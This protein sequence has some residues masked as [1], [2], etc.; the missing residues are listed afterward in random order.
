M[1]QSLLPSTTAWSDDEYGRVAVALLYPAYRRAV[2]TVGYAA[3][4][5]QLNY[6]LDAKLTVLSATQKAI[7]LSLA[8]QINADEQSYQDAAKDVP[9]VTKVGEI[10][11]DVEKGLQRRREALAVARAR[12]AR[13]VDHV[14][15]PYAED[16]LTG[17]A[18]N[19][20][21]AICVNG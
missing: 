17:G 11:R 16:I 12:L 10:G 15:N 21:N 3:A 14:V 20:I 4:T 7:V 5:D 13:Q 2:V 18:S 8:D 1:T 9:E 19:S 6:V